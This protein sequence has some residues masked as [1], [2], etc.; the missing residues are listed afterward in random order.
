VVSPESGAGAEGETVGDDP[1]QASLQRLQDLTEV[2]DEGPGHGTLVMLRPM[3]TID[4]PGLRGEVASG[5]TGNEPKAAVCTASGS[6]GYPWCVHFTFVHS[7]DELV[8]RERL[9]NAKYD[10]QRILASLTGYECEEIDGSRLRGEAREALIKDARS[11]SMVKHVVVATV[12]GS[13][14]HPWTELGYDSTCAAR[15]RLG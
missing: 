7:G 14:E 6:A 4:I 2:A 5:N 8:A 15:L 9:G 3:L 12:V 13:N 11:V 10:R 1:K